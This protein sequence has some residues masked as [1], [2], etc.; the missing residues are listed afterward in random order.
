MCVV[1]LPFSCL[2][3][4]S[5]LPTDE[6]CP[7]RIAGEGERISIA[8]PAPQIREKKP[9]LAV[10]AGT[11]G[12]DLAVRLL[13]DLARPLEGSRQLVLL[14]LVIVVDE[15]LALGHAV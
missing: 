2:D 1:A 12:V 11:L 5:S 15:L 8:L 6:T 13:V 4:P 9:T 3:M 14:Y 7:A 10:P